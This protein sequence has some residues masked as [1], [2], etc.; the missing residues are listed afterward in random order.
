MPLALVTGTSTGI[1]LAT[2]LHLAREGFDVRAALRN[3]A[4]GEI[5]R[6]AT[7]AESLP[8]EIVVMDVTE[9]ASVEG[10]IQAIF[11]ADGAIDVLVNNAGLGGAAPLEDVPDNE[12]RA[13][14][15][16]NYWGCIR[17]IQAVLP[18][19]GLARDNRRAGAVRSGAALEFGQRFVDHLRGENIIQ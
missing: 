5:L 16:A 14:F 2:A 11:A 7:E 13:M 15:E 1:G 12:H 18:H 6:K 9:D 4:R 8:V 3:P 17:T 19:K 10:C